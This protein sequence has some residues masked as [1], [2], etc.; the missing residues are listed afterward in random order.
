MAI[1]KAPD[2]GLPYAYA[3]FIITGFQMVGFVGQL[4]DYEEKV[5]EWTERTDALLEPDSP[6]WMVVAHSK[7]RQGR[8]PMPLRLA[9]RASLRR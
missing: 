5:V 8:Y 9:I 1:E 2:W 3:V 7:S 4:G 6:H